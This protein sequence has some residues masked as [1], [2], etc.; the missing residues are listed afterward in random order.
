[1]FHFFNIAHK[2]FDIINAT[3]SIELLIF[4][5]YKGLECKDIFIV[6][7]F[8]LKKNLLKKSADK[9]YLEEQKKIEEHFSC[10]LNFCV[11]VYK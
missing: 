10:Q 5:F 9:G 6:N 3:C 4:I 8:S 1:M 7:G 11:T 2:H